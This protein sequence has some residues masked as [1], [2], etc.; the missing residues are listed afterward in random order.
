MAGVQLQTACLLTQSQLLGNRKQR[1]NSSGFITVPKCVARNGRL[2]Q[3]SARGFGCPK[4]TGWPGHNTACLFKHY[5]ARDRALSSAGPPSAS[6]CTC[7]FLYVSPVVCGHTCNRADR[8]Q[9][10]KLLGVCSVIRSSTHSS[11]PS[12]M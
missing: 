10:G 5:V 8:Q 3:S 2:L 11:M 1:L 7:Q 6:H 9:A 12:R 4:Y